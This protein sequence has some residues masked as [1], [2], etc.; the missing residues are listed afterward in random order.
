MFIWRSCIFITE[1]SEIL[2]IMLQQ[3]FINVNVIAKA[4]DCASKNIK[5]SQ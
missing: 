2:Q 5:I 1:L 3:L 4:T